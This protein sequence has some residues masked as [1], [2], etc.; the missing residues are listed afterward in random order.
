[1]RHLPLG[2]AVN[3]KGFAAFSLPY[4]GKD[5]DMKTNIKVVSCFDGD[6]E[7]VDFFTDIFVNRIK[8]DEK[9]VPFPKNEEIVVESEQKSDY[10]R[11]VA[12]DHHH[13]PGLCG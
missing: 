8:E 4:G 2:K 7:A 11:G 10:N 13:A 12:S 3:P 5:Y 9:I 6:R 1:M